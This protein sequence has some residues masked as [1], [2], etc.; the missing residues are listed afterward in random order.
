M[1]LEYPNHL[2]T[3]VKFDTDVKGDYVMAAGQKYTVCDPTYIGAGIGM[4]MPTFK[5]VKPKVIKL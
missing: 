1:L 5:G 3:A 2:A 4:A